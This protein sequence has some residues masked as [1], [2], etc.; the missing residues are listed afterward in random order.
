MWQKFDNSRVSMR[1]VIITSILQGLDKKFFF[2]Q[3][4]FVQVQ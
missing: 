3:V 2:W 4:L 1:E